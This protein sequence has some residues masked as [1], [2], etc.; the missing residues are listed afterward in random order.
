[1]Y[2]KDDQAKSN[3]ELINPNYFRS[4]QSE[5][6][7]FELAL[8]LTKNSSFLEKRTREQLEQSN[9]E[10]HE[11]YGYSLLDEAINSGDLRA[12]KCLIESGIKFENDEEAL[13]RYLRYLFI[14]ME[15]V[16]A[17]FMGDEE[18]AYD[19]SPENSNAI[20]FYLKQHLGLN[21]IHQF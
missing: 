8:I 5:N 21:Q 1:M 15:T 13:N 17:H 3:E 18:I 10:A 14:G 7:P 4:C 2:R 6:V 11:K 16:N 9:I 12:V 19:K 20:L